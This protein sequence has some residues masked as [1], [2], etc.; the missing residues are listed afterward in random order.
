MPSVCAC[1]SVHRTILAYNYLL[2]IGE[3][4]EEE[5]KELLFLLCQVLEK[6]CQN[7]L[8]LAHQLPD[9]P[10]PLLALG[11]QGCIDDL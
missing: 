1:G 6:G 3:V 7:L 4:L 10:S 2:P 9:N 11:A 8:H 5:W